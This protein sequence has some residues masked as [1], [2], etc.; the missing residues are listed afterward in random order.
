ME[1]RNYRISKSQYLKGIQCPKALWLYRHRPDLAPEISESQQYLFDIGHEI[2]KLAQ[3]YFRGGIEITAEH[4][5]I[6]KSIKSTKSAIK[7]GQNILFEATACSK[8]GAY[9]RIDILKKVKGGDAWDLIEVKAST[10]VKDYHIDDITLQRYAFLNAGYRIRKSIL[11][12]VNNE[13]VRSGEL[14][15]KKMFKQEGCTKLVDKK[16]GQVKGNVKKLIETINKKNEPPMEIGDQ[17]SSP[18]DCDYMGYC[19]DHVPDYSVYDIFKGNKLNDLLSENILSVSDIPDDFKVTDRQQIDIDSFKRNRIYKDKKRIKE[20]LSSLTY[21]LYY[22]DYETINHAIP[23]FDNTSP[24]QL[25]PFQ[26]SL[27]IQKKKGGKLKHVEFLYTEQGD[28]RPE[29]IKS[30]LENCGEKGSVVVYNKGFESR[31]NSELG[32][33]FPK[34]KNR[35]KQINQRMVDVMIPFKSRFLYHPKMEGSASLK[36]V[37]PAFVPGMSYDDLAISDGESASMLYLSCIKDMVSEEEKN[38]IYKDLRKYC[39]Q[40]TFAEV[41]LLEVLYRNGL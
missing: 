23:L 21:P 38:K 14:D 39:K 3:Q 30:L 19:W 15:L 36:D 17:C 26:F 34:F 8:D 27:H 7:Q 6:D 2:G 37:L 13:Y 5:E 18:F 32:Q 16:I 40:D 31:I 1:K 29:L 33:A 11:M 24:Y 10:S 22:L 41:K 4:Y 25:I 12:Y 9:S 28:P 35:L 20:F